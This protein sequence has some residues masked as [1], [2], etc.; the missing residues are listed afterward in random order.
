MIPENLD[1]YIGTINGYN[2]L[3]VIASPDKMESIQLG[4][5]NVNN[6]PGISQET[7]E[8]PP[9]DFDFEHVDDQPESPFPLDEQS[10]TLTSAETPS[11]SVFGDDTQKNT[12]LNTR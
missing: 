3:I 8:S 12:Q 10:E 4:H 11:E 1:L 5:N 6:K 2:N 7:F 9:D